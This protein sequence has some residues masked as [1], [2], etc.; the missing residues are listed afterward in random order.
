V[1]DLQVR[2]SQNGL[3][4]EDTFETIQRPRAVLPPPAQA[5][6][7]PSSLA[8]STSRD[9]ALTALWAAVSGPHCSPSLTVFLSYGV[10]PAGLFL[11][12]LA[13]LCVLRLRP[14][15]ILTHALAY[16]KLTHT[17]TDTC[18]I[19]KEKLLKQTFKRM[20]TSVGNNS[21]LVRERVN[22]QRT[23]SS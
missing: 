3:G 5:A 19:R 21:G 17:P 11:N 22:L 7:S 4:L 6:Q 9:G 8:L 14:Y 2:E 15:P 16:G 13:C 10:T 12:S 1:Q 18:I 23:K 20:T